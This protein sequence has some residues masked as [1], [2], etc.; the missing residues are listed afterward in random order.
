MELF[1]MSDEPIIGAATPMGQ[2]VSPTPHEH[3]PKKMRM[4]VAAMA[5]A[6]GVDLAT[7][8][9]IVGACAFGKT[10][11]DAFC[12]RVNHTVL[13][14]R[15]LHDDEPREPDRKAEDMKNRLMAAGIPEDK[16]AEMLAGL[17]K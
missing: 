12:E 10:L 17:T 6:F 14:E 4:T 7:F 15:N 2:A 9:K 1:T 13:F 5:S 8:R 3:P 16:M 11:H